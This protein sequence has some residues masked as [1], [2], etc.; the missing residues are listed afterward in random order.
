MGARN[1]YCDRLLSEEGAFHISALLIGASRGDA[2][3]AGEALEFDA[4]EVVVVV[5]SSKLAPAWTALA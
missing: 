4:L 2:F 3:A 5:V 1:V